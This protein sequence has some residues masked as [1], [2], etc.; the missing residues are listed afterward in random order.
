M[1]AGGLN[2][3]LPMPA[4]PLV[5]AGL[6]VDSPSLAQLELTALEPEVRFRA[7]KPQRRRRPA[8]RQPRCRRR[9]WLWPGPIRRRGRADPRRLRQGRRPSVHL[10]LEHRRRRPRPAR[11]RAGRQGDLL[12]RAQ[13]QRKGASSTSTTP[14]DSVPKTSTGWSSRKGPGSEKVKGPGPPGTYRWFVV[15]WGG[16]GGI[17]R[18]THWQVR[19]KHAGKVNVYHGKFQALNERSKIYTLKVDPPPGETD[20][21]RRRVPTA[22]P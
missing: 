14:R 22:S 20:R 8:Q 2:T 12:G 7:A 21:R 13:G 18:P 1:L 10:D 3:P 19:V 5:E 15:Y 16:F 11:H 6:A 9:R 4:A 17:A